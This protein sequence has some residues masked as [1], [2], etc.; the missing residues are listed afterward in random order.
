MGVQ[1]QH[2][3][4]TVQNKIKTCFPITG[5]KK[6]MRKKK[7]YRHLKT[8]QSK[9]SWLQAINE[10]TSLYLLTLPLVMLSQTFVPPPSGVL[11]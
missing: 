3:K 4:E 11:L 6:R 7:K 10:I 9:K 2:N 1:T 5:S 8:K